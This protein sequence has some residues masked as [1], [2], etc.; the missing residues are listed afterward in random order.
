MEKVK[1]I[2]APTDFSDL[3]RAGLR[4]ALEM[5]RNLNAEVIEKL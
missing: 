4:Y 5:A 1:R 2:L 3:S